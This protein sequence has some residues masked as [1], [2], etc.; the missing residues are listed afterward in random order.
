M[1]H[2]AF[3]FKNSG[4]I[5]LAQ[6]KRPALAAWLTVYERLSHI[7]VALSRMP[8]FWRTKEIL[9]VEDGEAKFSSI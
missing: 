6:N 3:S 8:K 4:Q 7:A 5:G 2:R 1:F 9:T